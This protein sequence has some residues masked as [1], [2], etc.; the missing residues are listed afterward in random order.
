MNEPFIKENKEF[1][2]IKEW[3]KLSSK[4]VA[5]FTT[6]VGGFSEQFNGTLNC[7]FHVG[8]QI[9]AVKKNR[10][11]LSQKLHFPTDSW[12]GC[13][14]THGV[15]IAQINKAD[16]GKGALNYESS[17]KDTDGIYTNVHNILLTLC[18][19]DCVPLY[20]YSEKHNMVGIAHAGWKGTAKG[21]A[22]EMIHTWTEKGIMPK[23]ILVAI[24]P[25]ICEKCYIVDNRVIDEIHPW[26]MNTVDIPYNEI[27]TGQ[28]QLN[29]RKLNKIILE[30]SGIPSENIFVT[31]YCTSCE[32][33]DFFSHR[34][35][36]GNTGRMIGF[37]G[38]KGMDD[39][40]G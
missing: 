23:D 26:L 14:Q 37:I 10:E 6:K 35:D 16:I 36:Q 13:E 39:S 8:D 1:F 24:G 28:Y 22:K 33:D 32:R 15:H 31:K 2:Y 4:I 9:E 38:L 27:S 30:K 40:E 34:R 7:G 20:F 29:L 12:V 25:S 11:L 19:A 21:I 5:G 17:V 18:F 3:S